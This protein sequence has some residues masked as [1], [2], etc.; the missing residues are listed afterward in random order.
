MLSGTGDVRHKFICS[1]RLLKDE[2]DQ[3]LILSFLKCS[4]AQIKIII[5]DSHYGVVGQSERS[6]LLSILNIFYNCTCIHAF[7]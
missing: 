3:L 7:Y 5:F 2:V 6:E 4:V 1:E